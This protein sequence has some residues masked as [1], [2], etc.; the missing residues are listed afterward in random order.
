MAGCVARHHCIPAKRVTNGIRYDEVRITACISGMR[1]ESTSRAQDR[2]PARAPMWSPFWPVPTGFAGPHPARSHWNALSR[3]RGAQQS[4]PAAAPIVP[5]PAL[6]ISNMNHFSNV[7]RCATEDHPLSMSRWTRIKDASLAS[8]YSARGAGA[9]TY[10]LQGRKSGEMG[11]DKR[12]KV[13]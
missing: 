10:R 5:L 2:H 7:S 12:K 11:V 3:R 4:L 6:T 13:H 1:H 8:L 9:M